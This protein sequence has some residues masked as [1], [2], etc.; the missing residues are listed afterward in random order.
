MLHDCI[1]VLQ[2]IG[3]F[4]LKLCLQNDKNILKTYM[5]L[6]ND[7]V[8]WSYLVFKFLFSWIANFSCYVVPGI[9]T[10][11]YNDL[12]TMFSIIM[13][14]NSWV[15]GRYSPPKKM[16]LI[17]SKDSTV[18][19]EDKLPNTSSKLRGLIEHCIW[20]INPVWSL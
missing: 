20:F 17:N 4:I 14:V 16:N 7:T 18:T 9:L 12:K 19:N 1:I 5:V 11:V 13:E 10:C 8:M 15:R 2:I 3:V 6:K